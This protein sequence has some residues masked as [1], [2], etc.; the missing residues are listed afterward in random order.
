MERIYLNHGKTTLIDDEDYQFIS[1]FKWR[2]HNGYAHR[3]SR[4]YE[5]PPR[6]IYIHRVLMGLALG[7]TRQVDH[8]NGDKLDNR[9]LNLR[10]CTRSQNAMNS[11]RKRSGSSQ[12]KGVGFYKRDHKWQAQIKINN[13]LTYLGLFTSEIEAAKAYNK[14]AKE[15]FKEFAKLNS[16][17]VERMNNYGRKLQNNLEQQ[18]QEAGEPPS[19]TGGAAATTT[20]HK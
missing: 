6:T 2:S 10:I 8:I 14:A 19:S 20:P 1:Q 12:Y 18:S 4:K 3:Y 16:I 9:R 11:S 7:D 15:H 17:P 13:K 5:G